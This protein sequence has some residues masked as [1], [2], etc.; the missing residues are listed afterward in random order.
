MVHTTKVIHIN[1]ITGAENEVYI[2]RKSKEGDGYFGNPIIKGKT[3]KECGKIHT[4]DGS[5][6]LCY[7]IYLEKRL[8]KDKV[9]RKRVQ[10]LVNKTLVCFCT[11]KSKCH[12]TILVEYANRLN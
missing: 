9:F 8:R 4:T 7:T 5:T 1:E 2:G 11:D 6:L 3:C 12:G 10:E